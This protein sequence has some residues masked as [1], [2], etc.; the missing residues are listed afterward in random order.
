MSQ[1]CGP[2]SE[3]PFERLPWP[4]SFSVALVLDGVGI[5]GLGKQIYQWADGLPVEAECL[6]VTTAWE[7][8]SEVSPWIVWLSGP[9]DPVLAGFVESSAMHEH[10]YLLIGGKEKTTVTRWIRSHLQVER[11]PGYEEL[12]RISHP[13]LARSVIGD[14]LGQCLP[15]GVV[16]Q[17]IIP[18]KINQQWHCIKLRERTVGVSD[19][20]RNSL[21]YSDDLAQ[22][23]DAF[24]MRQASLQIWANLDARAR[25]NLGGPLLKNAYPALHSILEEARNAGHE[26]PRDMMRFLFSALSDNEVTST[27][28]DRAA[29]EDQG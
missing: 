21:A 8:V 20:Q 13:A 15:A 25:M 24:N 14:Q 16:R 22:A 5:A 23:F 17:L 11:A 19:H 3:S 26:S 10:G 2:I 29:F 4:D 6:Y 18:D 7:S 9:D 27:V 28:G 12:V 1:D